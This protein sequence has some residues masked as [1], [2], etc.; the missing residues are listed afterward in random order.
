MNCNENII[1]VI[2]ARLSSTRLPKKVL[3]DILGKPMIWHIVNRM[4]AIPSLSKI[5]ISTTNNENDEP[6]REFAKSINIPFY[7]GSE[8]DILDRLYQTGKKFNAT[9]LV[10]V[11]ADCPLIDP[12]II[13]TAIDQYCTVHPRPD[14]IENSIPNT[15][16][17]GLQFGIFNFITL[18]NLWHIVKD[19]FWR[20][21]IYMYIIENRTKY[22]VI[23]IVNNENLSNMRWTVDYPEDL[24]FVRKIYANLYTKNNL[25]TLNDILLFLRQN[26]EIQKI[27]SKC[28]SSMELYEK[29]RDKN[30]KII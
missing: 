21:F 30:G 17:E 10:K 29:L 18:S 20:E 11:N 14:L 19:P 6:L 5:V 3:A 22:S 27:N 13:K 7:A 4:K 28:S 26:P 16:P 8:N 2:Q 9:A 24:E 12:D 25:F 15:F 23:N 1:G